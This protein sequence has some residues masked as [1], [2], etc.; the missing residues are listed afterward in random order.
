METDLIEYLPR[1]FRDVLEFQALCQTETE[2]LEGLAEAM[3]A[4][5]DNFFFQT[6]DAGAIGQW[7][8]VF[9]IVSSPS[10]SLSFRR[11]RLLNRVS[12]RP[13]FTLTFLYERLDALIGPGQYTVE[14]DYPNYTLYIESA[15]E[16][17]DYAMEIAVTV[18]TIKPCHI[19]YVNRPLLTA[20]LLFSEEIG[21]T[22]T[23]YNYT[24]GSWGLGLS[25]FASDQDLGVIKLPSQPSIQPAFLSAAASFSVEEVAS[26]RINGSVAINEISRS[27]SGNQGT[28]TYSVAEAQASLVTQV[29]LLDAAGETLT[30]SGVYVPI[31]GSAQF[32]HVFTVKEGT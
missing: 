15:A 11:A 30:S 25:P 4:V 12:T 27:V 32:K 22:K 16:D 7:E 31:S 9:G 28:V 19:V 14:A 5:A 20:E 3:G 23:I 6:M 29:E 8:R 13:P 1:W 17:Q 18:D 26:V 24:L 2:Q 10:E 21:L